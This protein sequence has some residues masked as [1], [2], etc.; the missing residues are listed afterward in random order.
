MKI[1]LVLLALAAVVVVTA[2]TRHFKLSK[3]VMDDDSV[4]HFMERTHHEHRRILDYDDEAEDDTAA[5]EARAE[6]ELDDDLGEYYPKSRRSFDEEFGDEDVDEKSVVVD[7]DGHEIHRIPIKDFLNTQYFGPIT[8]GTPGQ[9][10]NVVFDTGSSNLWVYDSSCAA[11]GH[12]SCML[13][14]SFKAHESTTFRHEHGI[15]GVHYGGG[16]IKARLSRDTIHLDN[17]A[18]PN[19]LFGSTYFA[20]GKFGK[21]DGIL[22]L[23]MPALA[24]HHSIPVFDHIAKEH[25][26]PHPQFAFYLSNHAAGDNSEFS[27]GAPN[28]ARMATEFNYHNLINSNDY[29]AVKMDDIE[30][31]GKRLNA[32]DNEKGYCKLV[33]DSGTSFLTAPF[34][35]TREMLPHMHSQRDCSNVGE[36]PEIAYII[37]GKRY[38]LTADDYVVKV[39][40]KGRGVQCITGLMHLD[41][42]APRGPVFILGDVFMRKYYSLFDRK[43][44]RVG[45]ALAKH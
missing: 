36:L 27:L 29:W 35:A 3:H 31:N 7:K 30:L 28:P 15:M 12:V 9:T 21:S 43:N 2:E 1:A 13:H 10:F 17:I 11:A 4:H 32:C 19:Q 23:A 5:D 22:G 38:P 39:H 24:T 45:L 34:A 25:L 14:N 26:L 20:E 41:V 18:I 33:V 6:T 8:I 42:P 37:E 16:I 44:N 40:H